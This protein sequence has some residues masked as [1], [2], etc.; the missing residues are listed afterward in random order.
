MFRPLRRSFSTL[1]LHKI[2]I[3]T[4]NEKSPVKRVRDGLPTCAGQRQLPQLSGAIYHVAST[5]RCTPTINLRLNLALA[6]KTPQLTCR[7]QHRNRNV[8][9]NQ[10]LLSSEKYFVKYFFNYV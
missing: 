3:N 9:D 4:A 2:F 10:L 6:R 8:I 7:Y 1:F 5:Q